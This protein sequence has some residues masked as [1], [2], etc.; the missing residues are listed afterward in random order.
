MQRRDVMRWVAVTSTTG[1]AGC[2]GSLTNR[3]DENPD[4]QS[5]ENP[6]GAT[7]CKEY[8]Y[9]SGNSK[10]DGELPWDLHIRN[11]ALS[12]YS[13]SISIMN[14]SGET[15]EE[16]VSCTATSEAHKEFLFDLS[17]D[18]QYRVQVSLN[19]PGNPEEASTTVSGWNR[20]SGLNEALRVSVENDEFMIRRVHYDPAYTP[21][22]NSM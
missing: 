22:E 12:S 19:R 18:V 11:I 20:I 1:A 21:T 17:P 2:I 9:K 15:P 16:V 14:L 10:E 8:V 7:P 6:A 13:V 5:N 3:S 4:T